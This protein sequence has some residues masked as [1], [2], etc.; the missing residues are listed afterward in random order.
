MI[1]TIPIVEGAVQLKGYNGNSEICTFF[2]LEIGPGA[3]RALVMGLD[4]PPPPTTTTPAPPRKCIVYKI[5]LLVFDGD[6]KGGLKS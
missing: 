4:S 1:H 5:L 2:P 6:L 3:K